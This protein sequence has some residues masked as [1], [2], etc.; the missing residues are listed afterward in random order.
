[1]KNKRL[2][3]AAWWFDLIWWAVS[4]GFCRH[5]VTLFHPSTS[6][7][8]LASAAPTLFSSLAQVKCA[9]T[10]KH[11][12]YFHKQSLSAK[13]VKQVVHCTEKKV[14][15]DLK[16]LI[17]RSFQGEQQ[18]LW[19][20]GHWFKTTKLL[21]SKIYSPQCYTKALWMSPSP[22]LFAK[23]WHVKYHVEC[24]NQCHYNYHHYLEQCDMLNTTINA[25]TICYNVTHVVTSWMPSPF[26]ITQCSIINAIIAI[27]ICYNV[28]CAAASSVTS[29]PSSFSS[30]QQQHH[31]GCVAAPW[32][33]GSF[34]AITTLQQRPEIAISCSKFNCC[35]YQLSVCPVLPRYDPTPC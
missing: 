14:C 32:A 18:L 30:H 6:L 35:L 11:T 2:S 25:I 27:T 3:I 17:C 34:L 5:F 24:Y 26:A 29:L 28:K 15:N 19:Y 31:I 21:N 12:N 10:I 33:Y 1:M 8:Y 13:C 23:I 9:W 22:S 20:R 16:S 7:I 4:W